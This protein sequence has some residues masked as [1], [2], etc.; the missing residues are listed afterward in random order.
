L[1]RELEDSEIA[2]ILKRETGGED[3]GESMLGAA[4][5]ALVDAA[6]AHGGG[7]NITVAL[8]WVG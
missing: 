3:T 5:Q 1:T 6:N 7:D 2:G 8:V 4:C